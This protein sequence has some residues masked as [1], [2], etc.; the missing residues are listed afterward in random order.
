MIT[1][2][3]PAQ[4]IADVRTM[5]DVVGETV[6]RQRFSASRVDPVLALRGD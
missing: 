5:E 6:A 3:D 1:G 4:P 2:L